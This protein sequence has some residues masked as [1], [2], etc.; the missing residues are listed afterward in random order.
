MLCTNHDEMPCLLLVLIVNGNKT[1]AM[2]RF[3]LNKDMM[4]SSYLQTSASSPSPYPM[5]YNSNNSGG[6]AAAATPTNKQSE[7][8]D[9]ANLFIYHIPSGA[10]R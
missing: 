3:N 9:G 6:A 10:C 7:G 1:A 8:P 2:L 5:S 4:Q